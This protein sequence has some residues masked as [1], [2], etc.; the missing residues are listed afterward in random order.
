VLASDPTFRD[1]VCLYIAEGYKRSRHSV[2]LANSDPAVIQIANRWMRICSHKSPVCAI[3]YHADQDL[4]EICAFWSG[5]VGVN[6]T[7]IRLQRKSNSAQLGGRLWRSRY[8]VLTICVHDTYFRMR[9]QA[10]SDCLRNG[11]LHSDAV[12][13]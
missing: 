13:A 3:Q 7:A 11:W 8:G 4:E 6:P 10:W 12:G 2:S 5:M 1:F 9:L